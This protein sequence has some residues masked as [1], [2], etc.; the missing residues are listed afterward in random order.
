MDR[1]LRTIDRRLRNIEELLEKD[2]LISEKAAAE[3]LC[4]SPKTLINYVC[5]KKLEGRYTINAIGNRVYYKSK[6]LQP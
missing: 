4:I 3:L 6:L 5:L 1:D 2:D